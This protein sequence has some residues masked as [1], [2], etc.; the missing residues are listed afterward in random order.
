MPIT[1]SG[2][3][4]LANRALKTLKNIQESAETFEAAKTMEPEQVIGIINDAIKATAVDNWSK[5]LATDASVRMSVEYLAVLLSGMISGMLF[6]EDQWKFQAVCPV[7][8]HYMSEKEAVEVCKIVYT[9]CY[10]SCLPRPLP[11]HE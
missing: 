10:K 8:S 11:L 6:E 2:S 9:Q 4:V 1:C 3:M 7:L 5:F